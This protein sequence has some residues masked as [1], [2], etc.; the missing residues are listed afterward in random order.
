MISGH[1]KIRKNPVVIGGNLSAKPHPFQQLTSKQ[2][3]I[4][5]EYKRRRF[6]KWELHPVII[7]GAHTRLVP[8]ENTPWLGATG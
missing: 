8:W 4:L 2:E 1:V 7:C 6:V 3:V 5:S